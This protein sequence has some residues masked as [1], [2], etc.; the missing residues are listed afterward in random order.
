MLEVLH[1]DVELSTESELKKA[2]LLILRAQA[3]TSGEYDTLKACFTYGPLYDGDIPSKT[4]RDY[5]MEDDFIVKVV[6]SGEEGYNACTYKGA[7]LYR[8]LKLIHGE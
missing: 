4:A 3:E 1:E 8:L 2:L 6:N 7:R 5:L